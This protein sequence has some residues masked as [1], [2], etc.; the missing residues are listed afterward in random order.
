[1]I[2]VS[3][4]GL[5]QTVLADYL[6]KFFSVFIYIFHNFKNVIQIQLKWYLSKNI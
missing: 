4:V 1:M 5:K 2:S 3:F 6:L